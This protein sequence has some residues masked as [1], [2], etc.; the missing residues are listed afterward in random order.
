M[1]PEKRLEEIKKIIEKLIILNQDCPVIVEGKKDEKTLR[2][3][4]LNGKIIKIIGALSEFCEEV[5]EKH[6]KVI[7]LTDWDRKGGILCRTLKR[8]L[9]AD[10]VKY[11]DRIRAGLTVACKKEIKDVESLFTYIESLRR[12]GV[13]RNL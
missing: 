2:R 1:N 3:L 11:D 8:Y 5:S 13:K 6:K 7:V 12:R 9:N 10:S 4:G